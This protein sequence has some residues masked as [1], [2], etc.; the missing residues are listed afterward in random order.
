MLKIAQS[1]RYITPNIS[2]G[3][4]WRKDYSM[5]YNQKLTGGV[6]DIIRDPGG[7]SQEH[8]LTRLGGGI[9]TTL[10]FGDHDIRLSLNVMINYDGQIADGLKGDQVDSICSDYEDGDGKTVRACSFY[11]EL[12]SVW[13]TDIMVGIGYNF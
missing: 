9:E 7:A 3:K 11:P 12:G 13:R 10:P 6:T 2:V 4:M 5:T 8:W 1:T